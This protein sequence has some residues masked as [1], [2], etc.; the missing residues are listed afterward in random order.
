M[1]WMSVYL[2]GYVLVVVAIAMALWKLGVLE[3][4]GGFWIAV[5]AILA[6]GIGIIM[7]VQGSG[8]KEM[9]EIDRR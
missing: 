6:V 5:G 8:R 3:R 7:A 2:V 4:I 9:I 1:K